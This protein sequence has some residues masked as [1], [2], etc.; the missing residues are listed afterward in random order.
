[1]VGL[2]AL[3]RRVEVT[4][5]SMLPTLVPGERVVA[6]RRYRRLRVGDVVMVRDP[7]DGTRWILKRCA[8]IAR[9]QVTLRGDNEAY[10][11]DSRIFGPVSARRVR[12]LVL[13]TP[14]RR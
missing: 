3:V 7:R 2:G 14:P 8:S 11:T 10:S 6:I 12:W 5:P 1:V 4:G 9:R 13:G